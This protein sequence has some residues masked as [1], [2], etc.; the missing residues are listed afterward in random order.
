M[1]TRDRRSAS[2]HDGD[3]PHVHFVDRSAARLA[4]A[5]MIVARPSHRERSIHAWTTPLA[6]IA[7][8]RTKLAAQGHVVG[9]ALLLAALWVVNVYRASTQSIS[10]DEAFTYDAFVVGPMSTAFTGY[11][12]NNHVLFTVLAKLATAVFGVS[13]LGLRLPTVAAGALYLA[14]VFFLGR[15]L[16]K[17]GVVFS[18]VVAALAL[19]P[20][21]LDFLSAARGYGLALALFMLAFHQLATILIRPG[22]TSE[23]AEERRRWLVASMALGGSVAANLAFL[24]PAVALGLAGLAMAAVETPVAPESATRVPLGRSRIVMVVGPG[25]LFAAALLAMPLTRARPEHFTYGAARLTETVTSLVDVSV[26]HHPYHRSIE[27]PM[28][29]IANLETKT[30][31]PLTLVVLLA[32]AVTVGARA[33]RA[34]NVSRLASQDRM[35][36]LLTGTLSLTLIE[37]IAAH[38][39]WDVPY[40]LD[41]TG[42]YFIPMFIVALGMLAQGA[43]AW[44]RYAVV[45]RTC[46]LLWLGVLIVQSVVQFNVTQYALWRFDAGTRT[47]YEVAVRWP[48]RN[49]DAPLR[50]T[51]SELL[52]PS[53]EYY[54]RVDTTSSVASIAEGVAGIKDNE[55]DFAIVSDWS[56]DDVHSVPDSADLVCVHRTSGAM[57]FINR[58]SPAARRLEAVRSGFPPGTDCEGVLDTLKR[59][60]VSAP[61]RTAR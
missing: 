42:L 21:I 27:R 37:L 51:A 34:R 19:N 7:S 54:R 32:M 36:L 46:A 24:F 20:F 25:L 15:L 1:A 45:V 18:M 49:R 38:Y 35:L 11:T 5:A 16:F 10:Y 3:V 2:A 17:R 48:E 39:L 22:S 8:V 58:A 41:R 52:Y 60:G 53:L 61:V 14:V 12:A 40:P 29:A 43:V 33:I 28:A 13:E 9:M 47:L 44:R 30:L 26:H 23:R 59:L 55:F 57:L 6:T 56:L 4:A 31:V 50:I